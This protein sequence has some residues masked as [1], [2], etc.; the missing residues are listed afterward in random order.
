MNGQDALHWRQRAL[1]EDDTELKKEFD[2]EELEGNVPDG[3][4][5]HVD[6]FLSMNEPYIDLMAAVTIKGSLG[7]ATGICQRG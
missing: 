3:V 1:R 4:E 6:H 2:R 7:T 5:A